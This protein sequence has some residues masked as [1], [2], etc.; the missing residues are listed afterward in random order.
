MRSRAL[1]H[2]PCRLQRPDLVITT[3]DA[4]ALASIC[5]R[6]D[7][8]A[9]AIELAAARVRAMSVGELSTHLDDRFALLSGGP[10]GPATSSHIAIADRLELRSC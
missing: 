5:R 3:K 10:L 8:I 9:L 7:G 1:V 6:L 4:A 2:R